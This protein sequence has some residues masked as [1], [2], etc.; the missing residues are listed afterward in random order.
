MAVCCC[1]SRS[2]EE[3][4]MLQHSRLKSCTSPGLQPGRKKGGRKLCYRHWI[5]HFPTGLLLYYPPLFRVSPSRAHFVPMNTEPHFSSVAPPTIG[6]LTAPA[7]QQQS[8]KQWIGW[9]N[10]RHFKH[11]RRK[12]R[13]TQPRPPRY[14]QGKIIDGKSSWH[15]S[16]EGCLSLLL[17]LRYSWSPN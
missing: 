11:R 17:V 2:R 8:T 1:L 14:L 16:G 15:P 12:I 9:N 13:K 5:S 10:S 4:T 3:A 7:G 6:L